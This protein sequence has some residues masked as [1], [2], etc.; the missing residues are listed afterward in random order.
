MLDMVLPR[1][2]LRTTVIRLLRFMLD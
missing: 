1:W 2:E